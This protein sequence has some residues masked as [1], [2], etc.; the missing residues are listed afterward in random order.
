MQFN[1]M[2]AKQKKAKVEKN[3]VIFFPRCRKKHNHKECP[4]DVIKFCAICTKDHPTEGFPSLPG[5]KE[6]YKEAEEESEVVCLLNQRRQWQP[7]KSGMP[8]DPFS[9]QPPQYNA[10]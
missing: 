7:R 3:L 10:Q 5:L 1:I 4:L 6:V 8:N 9:F 2:Q